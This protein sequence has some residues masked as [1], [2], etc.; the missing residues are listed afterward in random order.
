MSLGSII[1]EGDVLPPEVVRDVHAGQCL[2]GYPHATV[3][4]QGAEVFEEEASDSVRIVPL[5]YEGVVD[6]L[7]R[8]GDI[9]DVNP[10][11]G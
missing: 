6:S 11:T 3:G 10:D 8:L 1:R 5:G 7:D 4:T 9:M 2:R